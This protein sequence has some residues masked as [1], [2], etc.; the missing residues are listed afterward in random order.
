MLKRAR[1]LLSRS[2]FRTKLFCGF[3]SVSLLPLVVL[4]ILSY[5]IA[6]DSLRDQMESRVADYVD[7]VS[8]QLNAVYRRTQEA[9]DNVVYSD[10]L[11]ALLVALKNNQVRIGE[12]QLYMEDCLQRLQPVSASIQRLDVLLSGDT[13]LRYN[14]A[15]L[16]ALDR[17]SVV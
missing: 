16:A 15:A 7:R 9:L 17:K 12:V 2:K 4:G 8:T 3:L 5:T 13:G 1:R 6:R 11:L 10:E 14:D